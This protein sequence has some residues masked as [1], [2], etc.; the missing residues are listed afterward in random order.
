MVPFCFKKNEELKVLIDYYEDDITGT[1]AISSIN[2]MVRRKIRLG[3]VRTVG[4]LPTYSEGKHSVARARGIRAAEVRWERKHREQTSSQFTYVGHDL[5]A[6]KDRLLGLWNMTPN[7]M[8]L[9]DY[10]VVFWTGIER[11]DS[12]SSLAS[13]RRAR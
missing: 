10:C 9:A 2:E 6:T 11:A 5:G 4:V 12:L 8:L 7:P 1:E 3:A 13:S